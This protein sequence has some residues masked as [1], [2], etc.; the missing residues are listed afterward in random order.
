MKQRRRWNNGTAA[1]YCYL[2]RDWWGKIWLH[3]RSTHKWGWLPWPCWQIAV[4]V[5]VFCELLKYLVVALTPSIFIV[6]LHITLRQ[7]WLLG[8]IQEGENLRWDELASH[9][10]VNAF[11]LLYGG[12]Y[13]YFTVSHTK[14]VQ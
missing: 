5:M 4:T 1:G 12:L 7:S 6:G 3:G 9:L 10:Y 2:A 14:Q 11:T 13:I 8:T